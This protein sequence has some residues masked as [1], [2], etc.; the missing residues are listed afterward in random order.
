MR[1]SNHLGILE[2]MIYG[3]NSKVY[4]Y[5]E[6]CLYLLINGSPIG[7][8]KMLDILDAQTLSCLIP[9]NRVSI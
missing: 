6:T 8:R 7:L 2:K 9:E 5:D 3:L 4:Y 1:F